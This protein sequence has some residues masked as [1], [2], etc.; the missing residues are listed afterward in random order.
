MP[1]ELCAGP[2][3][4]STRTTTAATVSS[5]T[6]MPNQNRTFGIHP[7]GSLYRNASLRGRVGAGALVDA[8]AWR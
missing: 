1:P 2:Q 8:G 6:A 7:H 3:R 5:M 4:V